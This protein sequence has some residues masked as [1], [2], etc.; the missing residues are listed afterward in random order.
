[1]VLALCAVAAACKKKEDP[2]PVPAATA[3]TPPVTVPAPVAVPDA[4]VSVTAV[5]LGKAIGADRKVAEPTAEFASS[6]TVHAAISTATSDPAR[7]IP[8]RLTAKWL[9]GGEQTLGEETRAFDFLGVG[10]SVF[11]LHRAGGWR[12]GRYRIDVLLDGKLA[13][14]KEFEVR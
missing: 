5:E 1:M 13:A 4:I 8:G 14:S 11:Q 10:V 6:D 2:S 3:E 9:D 12:P 7:P